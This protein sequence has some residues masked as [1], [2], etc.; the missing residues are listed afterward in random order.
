MPRAKSG[1]PDQSA[2]LPDGPRCFPLTRVV[3]SLARPTTR[4][5]TDGLHDS[6]LEGR[7]TS[8]LVSEIPKFPASWEKTGNY[9]RLG[10]ASPLRD[11]KYG[12]RSNELRRN[13]LR[14]GTGNFLR[15]NRELNRAIRECSTLISEF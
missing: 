2:T 11:A 15:R 14:I 13:S 7:V 5:R 1:L 9:D 3:R 12:S 10:L 8:E 6:P 4:W